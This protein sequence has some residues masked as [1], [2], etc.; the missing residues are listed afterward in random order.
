MPR[1]VERCL[2]L[3]LFLGYC[4]IT[5]KWPQ[6]SDDREDVSNPGASDLF[7]SLSTMSTGHTLTE[8]Q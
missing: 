7:R 8:V 5:V 4:Q 3:P 1:A 6:D 2:E